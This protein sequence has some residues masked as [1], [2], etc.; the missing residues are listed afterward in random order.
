MLCGLS[1]SLTT[2]MVSKEKEMKNKLVN[3]WKDGRVKVD[4][5]SYQITMEIIAHVTKIPDE[6]L[7]FY[8]DKKVFANV[9][10]DFTK[11]K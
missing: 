10:K 6:G 8:R 4:D 7:K 11:N 5:V 9:V 2:F 3:L 1:I